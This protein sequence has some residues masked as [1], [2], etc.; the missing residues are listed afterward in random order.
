[1]TVSPNGRDGTAYAVP[2]L[3]NTLRIRS[4]ITDIFGAND[5]YSLVFAFPYFSSEYDRP[6]QI[7]LLFVPSVIQEFP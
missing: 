5:P 2:L 6:T 4:K 3:V 7:S 1:M